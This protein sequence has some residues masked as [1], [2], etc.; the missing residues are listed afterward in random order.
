MIP[1]VLTLLRWRLA[2]RF[3]GL[4]ARQERCFSPHLGI[5]GAP[6]DNVMDPLLARWEALYGQYMLKLQLRR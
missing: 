2:G 3:G 5:N 6:L 1:N 4:Q